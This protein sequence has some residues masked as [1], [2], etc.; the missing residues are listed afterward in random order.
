MVIAL[1]IACATNLYS[2][3]NADKMVLRF[4]NAKEASENH[5]GQYYMTVKRLAERANLP[6]PKIY[7]MEDEQPNAFATGRNPENAAVVATTGLLRRL[8]PQEMAG[9]MAHELAH[10]EHRD[11]LT[12]TIASCF[13]GA[14]SML[15]NFGFLFSHQRSDEERSHSSIIPTLLAM[16]I[17]PFAAMLIQMAISRTREYEADRRGGEICGNP[18]WLANALARISDYKVHED[19]EQ[20][21]HDEEK[22]NTATAHMFIINPLKE[23]VSD[24]IF[25]THPATQNRIHALKKQAQI[26][27]IDPNLERQIFGHIDPEGQNLEK[28]VYEENKR[29][30]WMRF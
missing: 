8:N 12:M 2:Y 18:I 9:V 23:G 14:I 21:A 25:T 7:I 22:Y 6:T 11:I 3:W 1:I 30:N 24:N 27:N 26:M 19:S 20:K 28:K 16:F 17:A 29:P 4:Y 10:V 15:A 5:Y 13:A